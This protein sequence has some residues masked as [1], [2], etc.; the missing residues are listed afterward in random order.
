MR[1]R[2]D[3]RALHQEHQ[4]SPEYILYRPPIPLST[5]V[6]NLLL[7][8]ILPFMITRIYIRNNVVPLTALTRSKLPHGRLLP[9]NRVVT[10]TDA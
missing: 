5:V 7:L 1:S 4:D 3:R 2:G 9:A 6:S 10:R 8:A